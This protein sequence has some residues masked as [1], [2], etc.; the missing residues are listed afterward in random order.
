MPH[1]R[2]P[3]YRGW[4]GLVQQPVVSTRDENTRRI[5]D[6]QSKDLSAGRMHSSDI[7]KYSEVHE[8]VLRINKPIDRCTAVRIRNLGK[9]YD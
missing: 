2:V 4:E 8:G 5:S 7:P 6:G 1:P 3:Q 9:E